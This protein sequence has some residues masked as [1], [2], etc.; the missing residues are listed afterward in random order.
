MSVLP[1]SIRTNIARNARISDTDDLAFIDTDIAESFTARPSITPD[2]AAIDI[3]SGLESRATR[4]VIGTD[5]KILD[6]LARTNPKN[7]PKLIQLSIKNNSLETK[8]SIFRK[9]SKVL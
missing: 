4:L 3:I 7:Y 9:P 8:K 6:F 2:R 5:G 1:G